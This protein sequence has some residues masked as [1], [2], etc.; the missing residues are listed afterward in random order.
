MS[1]RL[2]VHIPHE[3]AAQLRYYVY[4]LRDPRCGRIFYVG[5]GKGARINSHVIEAGNNPTSERAK[6]R[7]I[8]EIESEGRE[9]ELLFL[10]TELGESEAFA[11]EQAVID[12][13]LADGHPLTN[14]VKGH[15][16]G[17][18]GLAALPAVVA[19]YGA[20]PCPAI[21]APVIMVKMQRGWRADMNAKQVY[22]TTRG[23]WKVGPDVRAR[24][25][26]CLGIAHG[27][28]RGAYRIDDW[29]ESEM[30][31][32]AGQNRWGFNGAGAVELEHVV[33]THVR[34]VFPN[35]VM[36]RKFLQGYRPEEWVLNSTRIVAGLGS[37]Q[38]DRLGDAP[39]IAPMGTTPESE[40]QSS[41]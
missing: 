18:L 4:A 20:A 31:W 36:Y 29:F 24:A 5:K 33:G 28:V 7:T 16:S 37:I 21:E 40:S 19:R 34:E 2:V 1:G 23:H 15:D 26:Y 32:D 11:V 8:N 25:R 30:E 3:V 6:L 12:A 27:V 38:V 14:L 13:F 35:Q 9:V 39:L 41:S 17:L 10:R 22:D